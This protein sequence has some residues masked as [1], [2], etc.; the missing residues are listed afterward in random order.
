MSSHPNI[1]TTN[2]LHLK[3]KIYTAFFFLSKL[4]SH[5]ALYAYNIVQERIIHLFNFYYTYLF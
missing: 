5:S 4:A 2:S 1:V 3:N